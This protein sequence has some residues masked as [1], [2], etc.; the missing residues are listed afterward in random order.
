MKNSPVHWS[1]RSAAIVLM[2]LQPLIGWPMYTLAAETSAAQGN[3]SPVRSVNQPSPEKVQPL[4]EPQPTVTV[5]RTVPEVEG[6]AGFQLSD[7]P[8]DEEITQC[9]LFSEPL[10][11]MTSVSDAQENQDLSTVLH[12]YANRKDADDVSALTTFCKQHPDSRW[13]VAVLYNLAHIYYFQ[14]YYSKALANWDEAWHGA[15]AASDVT[16][17]ALANQTLAQL[18]RMNA[19]IGRTDR[20]EELLKESA[21]RQI[22]GSAAQVLANLKD[23]LVLMKIDPGHSFLC[24]PLALAEIRRSQHISDTGDHNIAAA[25]STYK[26]CSFNQVANLAAAAGMKYQIARR[27]PGAAIITPAVVHWKLGHFAA[28]VKEDHGKYL[29]KDL[30][31]KNNLWLTRAAIDEEASGYFLVPQGLLPTG[32][33]TVAA[34]EVADVWG[35]GGTDGYDPGGE[36]PFDPGCGCGGG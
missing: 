13:R 10:V 21:S 17:V 30:T 4:L 22:A 28:L 33:H 11:P 19:R 12:L 23:A 20:L 1:H 24:G 15:K 36:T 25:Q 2:V 32:W 8:S 5:N 7:K 3:P 14:G 29:S 31:F 6:P 27:D 34:G 26:G 16:A 9:G 18:A 35:C